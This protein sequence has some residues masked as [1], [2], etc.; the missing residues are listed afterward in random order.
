MME[1][2]GIYDDLQASEHCNPT[3][4]NGTFNL[5]D[6]AKELLQQKTRQ[7]D[8]AKQMEAVARRQA[9]TRSRR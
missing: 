6:R 5:L 7:E 4:I 1:G 9:M 3:L 8:A 2:K